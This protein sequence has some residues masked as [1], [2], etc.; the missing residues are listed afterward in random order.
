MTKLLLNARFL[1]RP[2]SGVDRVATELMSALD[3]H[4]LPPPFEEWHAVKPKG[5]AYKGSHEAPQ[6]LQ[7]LTQSHGPFKGHLWE[8]LTLPRTAPD[9]WLLSLCNSGP[10]MRSKHIVMM[11]DAQVFR[12]PESYG[13]AYRFWHRRLQPLLGQRAAMILTVSQHSKNELV[14]FGIAP[15]QKIRVVPNGADHILRH[16]AD[17]TVL[18]RNGLSSNGFFLAIGSAAPHKNIPMLVQAAATRPDTTKPLVVVGSG[19]SGVFSSQGTNALENT[20]LI[21][22]VTDGELRALYENATALLF[23]SLTEGFGL[24]PLEAMLCGCPVI[25]AN[26]GAVPEN[27]GDAVMFLD[28]LNVAQWSSAMDGLSDDPDMRG[29]LAGLGQKHAAAFTWANAASVLSDHLAEL[30]LLLGQSAKSGR[31]GIGDTIR[32]TL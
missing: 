8:Q 17:L 15:A 20:L 4:G 10:V 11:H 23:P 2:P 13:R 12:V 24:P 6:I 32:R 9:D 1:T 25:A 22:R 3:R 26:A 7:R 16:K 18:T 19:Q 30:P 5:Q 27:C 29:R 21:G 28:P 31:Y 14:E